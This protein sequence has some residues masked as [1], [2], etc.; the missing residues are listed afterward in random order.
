MTID[1]TRH[2]GIFNINH[3]SACLIGAGGI[4]ALTA[5]TLGKM[6][7]GAISIFDI[8]DV[9]DVNIATQFFG[10]SDVGNNKA[11]AVENMLKELAGYS[12]IDAL[13]FDVRFDENLTLEY[14][15]FPERDLYISAVDSIESR[16][17]IWQAINSSLILP[18]KDLT[19]KWYLD[20]RMGAEVFELFVVNLNQPMWYED[21]IRR[22][23]DEDIP[24]LPCTSKATIYTANIAAGHIGAAVRRIATGDQ[25]PGFLS[26]D[27]INNE[28]NTI[29]MEML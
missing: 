27:I 2:M 22:A 26:H 28:L 25:V 7:V 6:G 24:D 13:G 4:G 11:H 16:K 19:N 12:G 9:D 21:H 17:G 3:L 5:I 15:L 10:V 18:G 29:E 14:G 1:H 20:A 23:S 8:D